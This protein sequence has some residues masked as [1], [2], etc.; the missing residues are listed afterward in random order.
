MVYLNSRPTSVTH[1]LKQVST[2]W[3]LTTLPHNTEGWGGV[4]CSQTLA[5]EVKCSQT[6]ACGVKCW[7][8]LACGAKYLHTLVLEKIHTQTTMYSLSFFALHG[9]LEQWG[10]ILFPLEANSQKNGAGRASSLWTELPPIH[11]ASGGSGVAGFQCH[12]SLF[13]SLHCF[14]YESRSLSFFPMFDE[15]IGFVIRWSRHKF[16]NQLYLHTS[17]FQIRHIFKDPRD[18]KVDLTLWL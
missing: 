14:S 18:L 3:R 11:P 1:F 5:C 2:F 9:I 12:R 4:K 10:F 16:F 8:T 6:L 17:L 15:D 7:Q 13:S